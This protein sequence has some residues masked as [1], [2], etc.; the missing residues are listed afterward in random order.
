MDDYKLSNLAKEDLIRIHRYSVEKFGTTQANKHF[1]SFFENFDVISEKPF[2]FESVDYIK[3]KF[4]CCVC[5]S[6]SIYYKI[7]NNIVEIM[8]IV[9]KQDL[10]N[11]L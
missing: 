6:D 2:F 5:G 9:G 10:K 7:N 4:R 8:V 11:I 1:D 3:T